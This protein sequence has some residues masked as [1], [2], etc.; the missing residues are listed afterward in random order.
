MS[1][2]NYRIIRYKNGAF[3]LHEVYYNDDDEPVMKTDQPTTFGSDEDEGVEGITSMLER[4]LNDARERP[5]LDDP[6][7]GSEE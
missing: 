5:V 2:W 7:P 1:H 3:G 6:W 4:A